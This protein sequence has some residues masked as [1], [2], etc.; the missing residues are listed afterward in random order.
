MNLRDLE[1]IVAVGKHLNFSYAA[2]ICRVSQPS[3]SAQIKK[4]EE[5]L[6]LQIFDRN[7]RKVEITPFGI[8]FIQR[9]EKILNLLEEIQDIAD[10]RNTTL[11]GEL[12]LGAIL[13]VAPYL[14]PQIVQIVSHSEPTIRLVLKESKTETLVKEVLTG[15][16]DTAIVS[17]PTDTNVFDTY[18]LF[19]ESFLLALPQHHPLAEKDVI[20]DD[21][22]KNEDL[23]LLEEGHCFRNQALEVCKTT[24]A[25]END[26]FQATSL[27]TIRHLVA[28]G[29]G[30]TLM[31]QIAAQDND[32]L[33]YRPLANPNFK[34][35][36][37][38]ITEKAPLKKLL[39]TKL[40]QL[41]RS[42]QDP[43]LLP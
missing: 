35:E 21:D 19:T 38:L 12:S 7:R 22:L 2:E 20:E 41:I 37:G 26:R 39:I 40:A 17:L 14:F 11:D 6:D 34:R 10:S 33:I 29:E 8:E 5:E 24:S 36:I 3:L 25:F 31:P 9:A 27:E 30:L 1:Y 18:P 15:P 23:I 16:L 43:I 28:A 32:G 4:V 13:T 42:L